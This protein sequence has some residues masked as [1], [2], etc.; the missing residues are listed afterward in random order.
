LPAAVVVNFFFPFALTRS[1]ATELQ[2][3]VGLP[4]AVVVNFFFPFAL[5]RSQA[6]ELQELVG[7]PE[8]RHT[9]KD[10]EIKHSLRVNYTRF[11]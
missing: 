5:T 2:E 3:L 9:K 11:F 6:T 10:Y 8:F 4:A 7:L 1:Q